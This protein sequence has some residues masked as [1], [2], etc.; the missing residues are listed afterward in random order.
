MVNS[1]PPLTAPVSPDDYV[2]IQRL[3]HRYSDAVVHRDVDKWGSCWSES[4]FWDFGRGRKVEGKDA[5]VR[6]WLAAMA[7]MDAVVQMVNNGDAWMIGSDPDRAAGR[8]Y[9]V[10]RYRRADGEVSILLAH[11]DDEYVRIPGGWQFSK[12]FLGVHYQGAPDLSGEFHNTAD[13]LAVREP[14]DA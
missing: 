4:A 12:R 14:T 6:L 3:V 8:W 7:G 11:Y 1:S 13:K 9:V 2:A 10:E 5:I